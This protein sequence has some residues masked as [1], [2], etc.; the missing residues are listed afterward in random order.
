MVISLSW[1][2]R[3][4]WSSVGSGRAAHVPV[5]VT[6]SF[7]SSERRTG[8]RHDNASM[9]VTKDPFVH[10][11]S[12]IIYVIFGMDEFF[13]NLTQNNTSYCLHNQTYFPSSSTSIVTVVSVLHFVGL[14]A[15]K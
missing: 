1:D 11:Q 7:F 10:H 5:D 3:R 2:S 12:S 13:C 15:S 6:V 4:N 8:L 14:F 9:R